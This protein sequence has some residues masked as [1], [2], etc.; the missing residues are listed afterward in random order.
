MVKNVK[1]C[2]AKELFKDL[3]RLISSAN[4]TRMRIVFNE[5]TSTNP[6]KEIFNLPASEPPNQKI[7][8]GYKAWYTEDDRMFHIEAK[9][10]TVNTILWPNNEV[11][12][13]VL[14]SIA[15][16]YLAA[17][18]ST[19]STKPCKDEIQKGDVAILTGHYMIIADSDLRTK[20]ILSL[21]W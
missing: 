4:L 2:K 17:P 5:Q 6:L 15:S 1:S 9:R 13:V 14:D 11:M 16:R 20:S 8:S 12:E 3:K 7:W 18:L 21:S 19:V 10:S